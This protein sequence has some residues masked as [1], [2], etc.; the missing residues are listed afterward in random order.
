MKLELTILSDVKFSECSGQ[1]SIVSTRPRCTVLIGN[2]GRRRMVV[3]GEHGSYGR[4]ECFA[5]VYYLRFTTFKSPLC[6]LNMIHF[7]AGF[8]E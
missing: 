1:M 5:T 2:C 6:V 4:Q 7:R 3:C 8:V